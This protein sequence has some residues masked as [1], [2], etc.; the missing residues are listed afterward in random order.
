MFYV[1]LLFLVV[2]YALLDQFELHKWLFVLSGS[3]VAVI[4]CLCIDFAK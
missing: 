1:L 3:F 2:N 4:V